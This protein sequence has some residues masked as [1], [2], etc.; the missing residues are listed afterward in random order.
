MGVWTDKRTA[1]QTPTCLT[2]TKP[3]PPMRGPAC[4]PGPGSL[5]PDPAHLGIQ[6]KEAVVFEAQPERVPSLDALLHEAPR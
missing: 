3:R 4:P 6:V 5:L 1:G 2:F